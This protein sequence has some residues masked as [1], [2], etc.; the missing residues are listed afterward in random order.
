[1]GGRMA[2]MLAAEEGD[3]F[4]AAG[5]V[6]FGY[7]LHP[8]GKP[9]QLRDAHLSRIRRPML[10]IQGTRD[11]LAKIDL[12]EA[13]VE[14]LHPLA[15]LHIVAEADHSFRIPREPR[16]PEE[17]GGAVGRIAAEFVREIVTM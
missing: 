13:V 14:R 10:F 7:P 3:A 17:V 12:I 1:M 15:R 16:S 8:P 4:P 5:L 11:A 2:S 9:A 6:F